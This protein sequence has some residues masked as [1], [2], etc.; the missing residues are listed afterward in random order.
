MVD[1][2]IFSYKID[3]NLQSLTMNKS[4]MP[5]ILQQKAYAFLLLRISGPYIK[6]INLCR[7]ILKIKLCVSPCGKNIIFLQH[8]PVVRRERSSMLPVGL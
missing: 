6:P 8:L 4:Y 7:T 2:Y 1:V 5:Y 3:Q